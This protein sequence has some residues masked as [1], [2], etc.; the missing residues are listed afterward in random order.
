VIISTRIVPRTISFPLFGTES[1]SSARP[2]NLESL[3]ED[4]ELPREDGLFSGGYN[5]AFI[6][7]Y[8]TS[9]TPRY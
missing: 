4:H 7:Q 3:R 9:Y 8:W 2:T 1:K 6:V 5:E